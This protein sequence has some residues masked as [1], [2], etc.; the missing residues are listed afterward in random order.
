MPNTPCRI[1]HGMTVLCAAS[2]HSRVRS[3]DKQNAMK[4]FSTL[5]RCRFLEEKNMDAVTG[6]CGS[7]PAFAW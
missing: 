2:Q 6:L 4:I 1:R 3:V 7:G 5:G